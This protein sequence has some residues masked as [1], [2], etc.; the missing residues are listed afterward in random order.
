M[1]PFYRKEEKEKKIVVTPV[2]RSARLM[3]KSNSGVKTYNSIKDIT[4]KHTEFCKN[5]Y[6]SV[7]FNP[8]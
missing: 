4:E 3:L 1:I 7:R 2:R 6:L 8:A 5:S